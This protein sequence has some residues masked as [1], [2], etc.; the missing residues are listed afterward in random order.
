MDEGTME[1]WMVWEGWSAAFISCA[2]Y[3]V[4]SV[5][6][7]VKLIGIIRNDVSYVHKKTQVEKSSH[8]RFD[9]MI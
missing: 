5:I 2:S 1:L 7:G 4:L 9:M 3:A 6:R 8:I